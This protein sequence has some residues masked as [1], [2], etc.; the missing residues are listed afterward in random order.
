MEK[1]LRDNNNILRLENKVEINRENAININIDMPTF[2][3]YPNWYMKQDDF[4][5]FKKMENYKELLNYLVCEKLIKSYYNFE[6]ANYIPAY[7]NGKY[8]VA[9]KN[10]RQTDKKH[11]YASPY[12]FNPFCDALGVFKALQYH[13]FSS[14]KYENLLN[15]L[16]QLISFQVYTTMTDLIEPNFLF[17]EEIDGFQ[18]APISDF[19]CAFDCPPKINL[20]CYSSAICRFIMPSCDFDNLISKYPNFAKFLKITEEIDISKILSSIEEEYGLYINEL[21]KEH[22]LKHDEGQKE[23]IRSLH[24]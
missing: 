1:C 21:Y 20:Y 3:T 17:S 11:F 22:Y 2:K 10:F 6:T 19:D 8:G 7:A 23:F 18:L 12:Y 9:S 24:L 16:F 15:H 5:Y 13:F 14:K 4:Y